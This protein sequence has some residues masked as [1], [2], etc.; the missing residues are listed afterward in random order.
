MKLMQVRLG[1]GSTFIISVVV[2]VVSA[3]LSLLLPYL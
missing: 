1:L 3:L 2:I